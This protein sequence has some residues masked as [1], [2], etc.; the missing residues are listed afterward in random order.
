MYSYL[1]LHPFIIDGTGRR[2]YECD[3]AVKG[4]RIVAIGKL[5]PFHAEHVVDGSGL[6]L[7]P[8]FMD[9]H[10]H[11]ELMAL[12]DP[13][14]K[15]KI[16][17]GITTEV[18]GN[19]GIGPFPCGGDDTTLKALTRDILGPWEGHY[20]KSFREYAN[21]LS[22]KG[23]GCNMAFLVSHG[24][25]RTAVLGGNPNRIATDKEIQAMC[26]LLDECFAQGCFG[27]STG[28]YYAPCM[29]AEKKEL[30]ALLGIVRAHDGLFAV[31]HRCE[32]D[33]VL[34]SLGEVLDLAAECGVRLEVSHL[35]A[36]GKQNQCK[37]EKM[38]SMLDD[39]AKRGVDVHFDQYPYTYGSTSL[40]SLL[41]PSLLKLAGNE[42]RSTLQDPS[43]RACVR[44][45][46]ENPVGWDSIYETAGWDQITL[47]VLESNPQYEK[48]TMQEVAAMLGKDPFECFFD[49][50]CEEKGCALMA[51][52][53]QSEASLITIMRHPLMAFG[54][55]ALYA[56]KLCHPR[57]Y[58]AAIHLLD[59]YG[60]N[61]GILSWEEL[62][63][64]MTGKVARRIGLSDRGTIAVGNKADLVLFDPLRTHDSSTMQRPDSPPEGLEMVMVNGLV[65]C[66]KGI[67]TKM[68]N[69]RLL[70]RE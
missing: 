14:M 34:E 62:I 48:H 65:A 9:I 37:V 13:S 53:T 54:T 66:E 56:G 33:E 26:D 3:L 45:E 40:F 6:F 28:L 10:A 52:E 55:D 25:L 35:K 63:G 50:L 43:V 30:V 57:S 1:F 8:G 38:L 39:A 5:D 60:R 20:W 21:Q 32:G 22:V 59:R 36:L 15:A 51:D 19:C 17:Q 41:P 27:F 29:F 4:D 42:L 11:S 69:G 64:R 24:A 23:A 46:M 70:L 49:L 12:R 31:H 7:T 61:L 44:E 16:C 68:A 58:N 47:L 18:S 67:P 2:R